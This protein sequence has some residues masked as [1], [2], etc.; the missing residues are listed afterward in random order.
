MEKKPVALHHLPCRLG[1]RYPHSVTDKMITAHTKFDF[2]SMAAEYDRC[3]HLFSLGIDHLWRK[4][5]VRAVYPYPHQR[6]LD[7]CTGTG[8]VVY[9]F[10]KHSPV[11]NITGADISESMIDLAQKKQIRFSGK[12][13]LNNKNVVWR[14]ADAAQTGLDME[15]FDIVTCAF[16][17]RNIP[18]R[19]AALSEIHRILKLKGKL[20]ILEFS[21]PANPLLRFPYNFY[22][23]RIMP[24]LGKWVIGDKE[25]LRY[26]AQSIGG[27]HTEVDFSNELAGAGFKLI[28]KTS[29]TGGVVTLW[30]AVKN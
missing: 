7:L 5:L 2:T 4:K 24:L 14:M 11:Q 18:N 20:C 3:N 8:D 26:L 28:R 6:I 1:C 12:R 21:L 17:I 10:L 16:G 15:S 9:S 19:T 13:W 27:W 29:L 25:P 23:N 30:L 22:L